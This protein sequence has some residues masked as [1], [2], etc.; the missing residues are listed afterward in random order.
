MSG[1]GLDRRHNKITTKTATHENHDQNNDCNW[2]K[3]YSDENY[4]ADGSDR[5][6]M[7]VLNVPDVWAKAAW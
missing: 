6:E 4:R 3:I 2:T 7:S 5:L 1:A